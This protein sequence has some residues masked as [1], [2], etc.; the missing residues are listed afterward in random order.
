MLGIRA[1]LDRARWKE[2][3]AKGFVCRID[4]ARDQ[5]GF[6]AST[7]LREGLKQ[8]AEWYLRQGWL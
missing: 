1:P 6:V 8:T 3:D 4:K 2:I 7:D 5:L